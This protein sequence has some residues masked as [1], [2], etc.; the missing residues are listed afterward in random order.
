MI[1]NKRALRLERLVGKAYKLLDSKYK[2]IS[3]GGLCAFNQ[4][5][6]TDIECMV[7]TE[8]IE[9][10]SDYKS[11]LQGVNNEFC[12]NG[13]HYLIRVI[14]KGGAPILDVWILNTTIVDQHFIDNSISIASVGFYDGAEIHVPERLKKHQENISE[15]VRII[16]MAS[17][18]WVR[19]T[20]ECGI[21]NLEKGFTS[22]LYTYLE[23]IFE[24]ECKTELLDK[25]WFSIFSEKNGYYALDSR[26]IDRTLE[27]LTKR[28]YVSEYSPAY[29][30]ASLLGLDMP[31]H[32]SFSQYAITEKGYH[33]FSLQSAA[34]ISDMSHI[35][36]TEQQMTEG[37]DYAIFHLT[38]V[39]D[40][41]LVAS[42]PSNYSTDI[43]PVLK[44]N[45]DELSSIYQTNSHSLNMHVRTIRASYKRLDTAEIGGF[46]GGIIG[47]IWRIL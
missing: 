19:N 12:F 17:Y 33:Q 18:S 21:A 34:Y 39:A 37:A 35:L 41:Q 36:Q 23:M 22:E 30:L 2:N 29:H 44:K 16:Y 32:Q 7:S 25:I 31:Y 27:I 38:K 4:N 14:K 28:K 24:K 11:F 46:M 26:A 43:L 15:I 20:L 8:I 6:E 47:G 5:I 13:H 9:Y 10:F 1:N 3:L 45:A 42:F 40:R